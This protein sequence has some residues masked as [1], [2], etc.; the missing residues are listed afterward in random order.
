MIND[1]KIKDYQS[2]INNE[3][4]K[5]YK[6]GPKILKDSI[7]YVLDGN[8]KRIRPILTI[9]SAESC[10]ATIKDALPAAIAVEL[11]HNFSLVHDDIMDQDDLRRGR[12][13]VHKRWNM[14][15]AILTGD[16][17]LSLAIKHLHEYY[18]TNNNITKIFS[19]ALLAICEGQALDIEFETRKDISIDDYLNM[20]ELNNY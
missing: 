2:I 12:E 10:G 3:F 11:L 18:S 1:N 15:T 4:E 9:L 17:I 8:G 13:T 16:A 6:S 20:I 19:D 5:I 7:E 14:A